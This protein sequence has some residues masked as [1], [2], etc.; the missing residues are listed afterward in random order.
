MKS[1]RYRIPRYRSKEGQ[2]LVLFLLFAVILLLFVGLGIDMGFAY[3]TKARLSKALDAASLAGVAN[4]SGADSG[5]AALLVAEN[6]FWANYGSNG[7]SGLSGSIQVQPQGHFSVDSVTGNLT[8]TNSASATINTFFVGLIPQWKTLTVGDTAVANRAPVVMTLVL[9][10]SGSMDPTVP[11]ANCQ[12]QTQGGLYLPGAVTE[13]INIFDE[14]LD[15]AAL[16]TFASS[17]ANDVPLSAKGGLFKS[18]IIGAMS[19]IS[20][21]KLWAGGTCT[22]A[23]LTN[24]L[25]I[26]N[27]AGAPAT[28]V[29]AVILFTDGQA[30]MIEGVFS[31]VPVNFGGQDPAQINCPPPKGGDP[32]ASFFPTNAAETVNAQNNTPC[33]VNCDSTLTGCTINGT[34]I[35]NVTTYTDTTGNKDF[36]ASWITTDATNRCVMLA[37]QMRASGDYVYAVGLAAPGALAP[38]TLQMLQEVANDSAWSGFDKTVPV[39]AAFLSDGNDLSQVFQ[40]VA[41]DIILRL[42]R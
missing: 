11:L 16:V 41:A 3:I 26:E 22:E 33:T 19:R 20:S 21:N 6:T 39:G 1:S 14:K 38:P 40:Q 28:A 27:N 37:K 9:D 25:V 15:R 36:C 5:A 17:S 7:V 32:G 35:K 4:Y 24:A 2:V 31:G 42:V 8:F 12:G 30:N 23:G 34:K 13:F 18:N 29:R 10:R